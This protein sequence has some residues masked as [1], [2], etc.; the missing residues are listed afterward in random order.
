MTKNEVSFGHDEILYSE[1]QM[2]TVDEIR[3]SEHYT[4]FLR[5]L[6]GV[7][8]YRGRSRKQWKDNLIHHYL[9]HHAIID[10]EWGK[11]RRQRDLE[12]M[13]Q[14]REIATLRE[15]VERKNAELQELE[16]RL[17]ETEIRLRETETRLR[18]CRRPAGKTVN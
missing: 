17:K 1:K 5:L 2:A 6:E 7:L 18:E 8:K 13:R 4:D 11:D 10:D 3:Q 9:K 12:C 16:T 14:K 15:M